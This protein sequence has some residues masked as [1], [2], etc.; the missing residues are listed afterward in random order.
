MDVDPDGE[1]RSSLYRLLTTL[2]VPRP[3]GWISTVD[4]SGAPNLAPYSAFNYVNY[5]P[6]IVMFSA[7]DADGGGLK[8]TP[9]NILATEEFVLNLVAESLGEQMDATSASVEGNEFDRAGLERRPS[10]LVEPPRVAD[11]PAAMECTLHSSVRFGDHTVIFGEIV[12]V[13]VAEE[14]LVN[15]KIDA[16]KVRAIGRLGGPYYTDT[17]PVELQRE[18]ASGLE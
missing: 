4:E 15:G 9:S 14:L 3:I 5:E 12:R 7:G 8:D 13:H 11:A 10:S 2:V 16:R 1:D 17:R 18:F 6:P